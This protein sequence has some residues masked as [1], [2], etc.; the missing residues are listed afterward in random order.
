MN[1][2][3]GNRCA[4][5][6]ARFRFNV[7]FCRSHMHTHAF[8]LVYPGEDAHSEF[9]IVEYQKKEYETEK[10]RTKNNLA[11]LKKKD[12]VMGN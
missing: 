8:T 6:G 10:T 4:E 3:E 9:Q 2:L 5:L 12:F 1:L 11:S 7:A